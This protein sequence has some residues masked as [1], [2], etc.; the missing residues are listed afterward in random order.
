MAEKVKGKGK[1]FC[2]VR[3]KKKQLPLKKYS[4]IQK[5]KTKRNFHACSR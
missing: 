5:D 3:M 4:H 2:V 1:D